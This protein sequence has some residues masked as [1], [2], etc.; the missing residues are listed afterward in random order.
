[1]WSVHGRNFCY[2]ADL[3][4]EDGS[5]TSCYGDSNNGKWL[6]FGDDTGDKQYRIGDNSEWADYMVNDS[7]QV[8]VN[9]NDNDHVMM[10][11]TVNIYS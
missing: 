6:Q 7:E 10:I 8:T 4:T 9:V 2:M 1:M 11:I 5:N 3:V